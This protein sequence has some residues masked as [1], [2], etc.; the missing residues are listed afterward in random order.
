[1]D[2]A[3]LNA[4]AGIGKALTVRVGRTQAGFLKG[5]LYE[6]L[7]YTRRLTVSEREEVTAYLDAKWGLR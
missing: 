1:M 6:V 7:I 2:V 5:D 4:S 3:A